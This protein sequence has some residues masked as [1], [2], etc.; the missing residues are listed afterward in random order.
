MG[1]VNVT[2]RLLFAFLFLSSG[3]QKLSTFNLS[4]GGP[5]MDFMA[6]KLDQALAGIEKFAGQSLNVPKSFY[7]YALGAAIFLELAGGV[8]FVLGSRLGAWLLILFLASVTPVMHNFWD[9]KEGSEEQITDMIQFFKNLALF[10]AL[11]IFVS[12]RQTRIK[13]A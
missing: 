8:L 10:G 6:P 5:T 12:T 11:L 13:L 1:L 2:G 3:A 4:T 9:L 7:V